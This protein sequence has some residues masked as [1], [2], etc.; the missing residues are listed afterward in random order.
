MSHELPRVQLAAYEDIAAIAGRLERS[1]GRAA[2]DK[3]VERILAGIELLGKTPYLGPL[4]QDEMLARQGYRKLVLG[5][6]VAVYRVHD[7]QAVVLRVFYGASDY[8]RQIEA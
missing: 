6:Y 2:A 7:D 3:T 8:T 1:V 4:H 5:K